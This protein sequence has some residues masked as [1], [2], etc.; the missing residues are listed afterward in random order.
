MHESVVLFTDQTLQK[1]KAI[2][3]LRVQ[4]ARG[5]SKYSSIRL[6][7]EQDGISGYHRSCYRYYMVSFPKWKY[8]K[9][10]QGR[11]TSSFLL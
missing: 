5:K 10:K 9:K 6:P 8:S 2:Y 4:Y 11:S 3:N 1:V 7:A